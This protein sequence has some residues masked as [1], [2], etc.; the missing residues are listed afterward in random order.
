[1]WWYPPAWPL[2]LSFALNA[3]MPQAL[4][5]LHETEVRREINDAW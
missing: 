3:R 4:H 5:S 1:M 2:A